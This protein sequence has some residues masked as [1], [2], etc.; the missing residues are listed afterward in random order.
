[1]GLILSDRFNLDSVLLKR[2]LKLES[3][4]NKN[5]INRSDAELVRSYPELKYVKLKTQLALFH[6]QMKYS[7]LY[8]QYTQQL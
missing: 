5:W 1:M 4:N 7:D 6:S 2:Y 8:T 3:I